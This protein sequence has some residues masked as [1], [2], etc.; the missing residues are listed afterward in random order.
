MPAAVSFHSMDE[1]FLRVNFPPVVAQLLPA[2]FNLP[3]SRIGFSRQA[4]KMIEV[5]FPSGLSFDKFCEAIHAVHVSLRS[6]PCTLLQRGHQ[7]SI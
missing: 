3:N 2:V 4:L 1:D 5:L 6:V 7:L